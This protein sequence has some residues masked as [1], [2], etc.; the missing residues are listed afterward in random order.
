MLQLVIFPGSTLTQE[1]D[2]QIQES[3]SQIQLDTASQ[4]QLGTASQIQPDTASQ[5]QLDIAD[6]E[7]IFVPEAPEEAPEH[8][9]IQE[10][11]AAQR[12]LKRQLSEASVDSQGWPKMLK[13]GYNSSSSTQVPQSLGPRRVLPRLPPS[14][15]HKGSPSQRFEEEPAPATPLNKAPASGKPSATTSKGAEKEAAAS[16]CPEKEAVP[17]KSSDKVQGEYY[18]LMYYKASKSFAFRK[19]FA[20]RNQIF[21]LTNK[22]WDKETL[23]ALAHQVKARLEEAK[24]RWEPVRDWAHSK[25]REKL[26]A[27]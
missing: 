14:L 27:Q 20:E 8:P 23:E 24:H 15:L 16:K 17:K 5:T 10:K 1:S 12:S 26:L 9:Q 3:D 19:R 11:T 6:M 18:S 2:S 21:S 7:T 13:E 4:I 25:L 22:D